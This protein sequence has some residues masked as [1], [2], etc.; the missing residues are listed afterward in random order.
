[1]TLRVLTV[2]AVAIHTTSMES[3]NL[4]TL[5]CVILTALSTQAFAFAIYQLAAH[6]ELVAGLREEVENVVKN[7]GWTKVGMVKMRKMDSFIME[8]G[9]LYGAS[10]AQI[11]RKTRRDFTFSD[12]TTI[13][14]GYFTAFA[15][16][17]Q[18]HDEVKI[19]SRKYQSSL[20]GFDREYLVILMSLEAVA[21]TI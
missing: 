3:N 19:A 12:G 4:S 20:T 21:F 2:N 1:M 14:A 9:R 6:P 17:T 5:Y 16:Y 13:P 15:S 11:Q 8:S 18:H 10:P 7:D